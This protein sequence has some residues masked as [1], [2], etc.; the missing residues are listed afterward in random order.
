MNLLDKYLFKEFLRIFLLSVIVMITFYLM[1]T[2]IDMAGYF[3][4]FKASLEQVFRYMLFKGPVALLHVTPICVL[5]ASV[6]T[7]NG[8]ARSSELV[9]MKAAGISMLR[10]ATPLL[11]IGFVI[12]LLSFLNGEYLSHQAERETKRIYYEEIRKLP[13]KAMFSGDHFWYK[14]DDGAVWNIGKIDPTSHS[15]IDISIFDFNPDGTKT[16][17]RTIARKIKSKNG[18]WIMQGVTI[19]KFGEKG[20]FTEEKWESKKL[21]RA[22]IE[23]GELT[24]VRLD[25]EEMNLQQLQVLIED[26]R[27]RGHDT[28]KYVAD[29][30]S[31]IG[32]PLISFIMPFFA[33]PIGVRSSRVGG[34]MLG[35]GVA[36]VIGVVFWFSF[37]MLMAFGAAGR[38]YPVLAA[39]GTHGIFGMVGLFMLLTDRQ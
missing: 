6:L 12:S 2:F 9:A 1:V 8:F 31:K 37:S 28:S 24:K 10:I 17:K 25:P 39:Y 27:N 32:F 14:A 4:K 18:D 15:L 33:I 29:M 3:F 11:L 38:I 22:I 13:R 36:V 30:H 16:L 5:L 19:Y 35:I 26:T 34:T 7:I 23:I 20:Q 21:D